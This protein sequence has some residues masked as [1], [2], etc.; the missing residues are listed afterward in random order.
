MIRLSR[1]SRG[2]TDYHSPPGSPWEIPRREGRRKRERE[3]RSSARRRLARSTLVISGFLIV[4]R[5]RRTAACTHECTFAPARTDGRTD[6]LEH[7]RTILHFPR[8]DA[9]NPLATTHMAANGLRL[10]ISRIP[11]VSLLPPPFPHVPP[12]H[13]RFET[14]RFKK[15]TSCIPRDRC[16]LSR[17]F[18]NEKIYN[19]YIYVTSRG[20]RERACSCHGRIRIPTVPCR[21]ARSRKRAATTAAFADCTIMQRDGYLGI[22]I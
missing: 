7:V 22:T 5:I 21:G 9:C 11:K 19:I 4:V 1:Y 13:P 16:R 6:G 20:R 15:L 14:V 17:P 12:G 18:D 8:D 3:R 10:N 2:R